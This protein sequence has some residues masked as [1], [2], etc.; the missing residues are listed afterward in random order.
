MSQIFIVSIAISYI[1]CTLGKKKKETRQLI[2][3]FND[4]I[5]HKLRAV[6]GISLFFHEEV[7]D[8]NSGNVIKWAYTN[9][10]KAWVGQFQIKQV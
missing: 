6:N 9:G 7:A 1:F 5:A 8:S 4:I 2:A 10:K 3:L